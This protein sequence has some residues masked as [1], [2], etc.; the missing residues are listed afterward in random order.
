MDFVCTCEG[1][2][3][4]I[5]IYICVRGI[6]GNMCDFAQLEKLKKKKKRKKRRV[7]IL[8]RVAGFSLF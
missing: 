7:L 8:F 4:D 6:E 5:Y 1:R 3:G 2:E